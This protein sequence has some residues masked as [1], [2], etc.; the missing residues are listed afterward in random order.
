M[1]KSNAERQ[2]AF[3]AR[4]SAEGL[5]ACTVMVHASQLAE[6]VALAKLLASSSELEAALARNTR[7][8]RLVKP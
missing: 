5:V 2:R 1:A 8:G 6:L 7:T 3:R 4:K